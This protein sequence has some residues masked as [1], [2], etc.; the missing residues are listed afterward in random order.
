[1]R[2]QPGQN[3]IIL[4]TEKEAAEAVFNFLNERYAGKAFL[5][6]DRLTF[7]RYILPRS[8]AILVT[9]LVTQSPHHKAADIPAPKLEKIL[10]DVF[11]NEEIFYVFHGEELAHI[12]ESAFQRYQ[13]SQ[14]A[15]FRYAERRKVAQKIRT[16]MKQK[17]DIPLI[18]QERVN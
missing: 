3:Q 2:R 1:M 9:T 13:V 12:F 5:L 8:E 7:E 18:P 16:F 6:P 11:A 17:M 14:K 15:L 4:E 10:V